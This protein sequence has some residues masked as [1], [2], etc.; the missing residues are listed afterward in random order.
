[1]DIKQVGNIP[2]YRLIDGLRNGNL[3][4]GGEVYQAVGGVHGLADHAERHSRL[5]AD[6]AHD[7][8]SFVDADPQPQFDAE[9]GEPT[10]AQLVE[11]ALHVDR[12]DQRPIMA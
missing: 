3:A 8:V 12:R 1:D 11:A 7:D 4:V 5:R 6:V 10:L 9:L 2:L